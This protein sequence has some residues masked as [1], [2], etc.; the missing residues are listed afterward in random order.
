MNS[1]SRRSP[2]VLT[3]AAAV[4]SGTVADLMAV[5]GEDMA[6]HPFS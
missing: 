1:T 3:A 2:C 6:R 5:I 4:D